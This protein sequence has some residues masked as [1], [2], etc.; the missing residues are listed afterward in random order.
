MVFHVS[1]VCSLFISPRMTMLDMPN[2]D[3]LKDNQRLL[4]NY[5]VVTGYKKN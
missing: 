3:Y 4:F 5:D 2:A 1:N